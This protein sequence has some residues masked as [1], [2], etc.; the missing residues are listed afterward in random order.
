MEVSVAKL[1]EMFNAAEFDKR[2][3]VGELTVHIVRSRPAPPGANQVP[4]TLSQMI[5]YRNAQGTEIASAH[6]YLQP[7]GQLGGTG[8]RPDPKSMLEGGVLYIPWWGTPL[9][10]L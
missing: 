1:R 3:A 8:H 6:R 10:G 2:A 5:S 7:N 4:G 9:R